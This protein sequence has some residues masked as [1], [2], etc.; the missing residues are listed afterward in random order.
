MGERRRLHTAAQ[1]KQ[2]VQVLCG[3][4]ALA[5]LHRLLLLA[6]RAM[7]EG[8]NAVW[9]LFLGS[10]H[11]GLEVLHLRPGAKNWACLRTLACSPVALTCRRSACSA[12]SRHTR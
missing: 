5:G 10:L 11:A 1:G 4:E 3:W 12:R 9:P 8:Q 7:Q 2:G 6:M